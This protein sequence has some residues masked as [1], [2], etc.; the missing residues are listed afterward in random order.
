M[1]NSHEH[2]LIVSEG[3]KSRPE[4]II[5]AFFY[6]VFFFLVVAVLYNV[7]ID[8]SSWIFIQSIYAPLTGALF[9]LAF[10]LNYS[11]EKTILIDL[12][13]DKLIYRFS[14]GPYE[15]NQFSTVPKLEYVAVFKNIE[16]I[17]EVNLWFNGNKHYRMDH[18]D[19]ST[20]AFD[21]AKVVTSKL[22]LRLLDATK[23]GDTHWIETVPAN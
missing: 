21:F 5:A 23:K 16:G 3:K 10:A 18:F 6:T 4:K 20:E 7:L 15:H 14:F 17:Y 19:K 12:K 22:N 8:E 11:I 1:S 9:C 2:E 13:K